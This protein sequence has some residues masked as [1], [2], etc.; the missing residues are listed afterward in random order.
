M[1]HNGGNSRG[2]ARIDVHG[3]TA[4][5]LEDSMKTHREKK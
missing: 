4:N 3:D 5:L 1:G 2:G